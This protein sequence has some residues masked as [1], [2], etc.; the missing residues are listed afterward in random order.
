MTQN[1]SLATRLRAGV[2]PRSEDLVVTRHPTR[3]TMTQPPIDK[4]LFRIPGRYRTYQRVYGLLPICHEIRRPASFESLAVVYPAC[5]WRRLSSWPSWII[6]HRGPIVVP[7]SRA[8]A[9]IGLMRCRGDRR[10][11]G[12][13]TRY[14][15]RVKGLPVGYAASARVYGTSFVQTA[16][17]IRPN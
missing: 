11:M 2:S 9:A 14:A 6:A 1:A 7:A 3:S 12:S 5:R 15:L 4:P 8:R 17:T 16:Q 10:A 13:V